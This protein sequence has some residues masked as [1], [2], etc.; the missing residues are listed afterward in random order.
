M[1]K[2]FLIFGIL[3]LMMIWSTSGWA[4]DLKELER[5][6][7]IMSDELDA[8]KESGGGGL[9]ERVHVHGY[10]ELHFNLPTD[11]S[12]DGVFDN[13]R[14]VLGVNAKLAD[15]IHLNVEIDFEHAAQEMEFEFGYLDFL[16]GP[17]LNARAGVMLVPMGF[18][19]EYHEPPLFWTVERPEFQK[20]IIP[21]TWNASGAGIFGSPMD[22]VNYRLYLVNSLQSVRPTGFD[23][24]HGAGG[25]KGRFRQ[26][27]GIRSGRLQ[28]DAAIF[29]DFAITGRVELTKLFPGLQTGF[30]FYTGNT[31][32]NIIPEGGRTTILEGDIKYR[33][34]WFDMN[35]SM[36][37]INISDAGAINNFLI[38]EGED[39]GNVASGIFGWNIQAGV[40]LPQLLGL[41]TSQD[42]VLFALYE[43]IDTQNE[44]PAG[45]APDL[46]N[47]RKILTTGVSYMPIPE[48]ALKFDYQHTS[49]SNGDRVDQVNIGVAYMY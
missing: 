32:Q 1:R 21:T 23:D 3:G 36:A 40:H 31:T 48:V 10:G 24:G 43:F 47:E 4:Q 25:N 28:P 2:T 33:Y 12:K 46:K 22:G 45:F 35:A 38:A 42:L 8:L 14:Y 27:S 30:S 13:H 29:E 39:D 19:N 5:R 41:S 9:A 17:K 16:L 15:W 18:L 37:H 11:G 49:K 26:G 44:M 6:I 20:S 34:R 7:D